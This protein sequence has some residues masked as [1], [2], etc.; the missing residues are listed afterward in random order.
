VAKAGS[1][2]KEVV[3][4]CDRRWITVY[5]NFRFS[6]GIDYFIHSFFAPPKKK[7]KKKESGNANFAPDGSGSQFAPFPCCLRTLLMS[8]L[9]LLKIPDSK[10]NYRIPDYRLLITRPKALLP[11]H[12]PYQDSY[13]IED[14]RTAG[15]QDRTTSILRPQ[16]QGRAFRNSPVG[17]FS[18]EPACR[19]G[20]PAFAKASA[21]E[22]RLHDQLQVAGKTARP[23]DRQPLLRLRLP[24][25]DIFY[26][27]CAFIYKAIIIN[28]KAVSGI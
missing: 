27:L 6:D 24:T 10:T 18:E 7:S 4:S 2:R 15:P 28:G 16:D 20:L 8:I 11:P 25:H 26:Y 3:Q 9:I 23:Q 1:R 17:C 13:L 12:L 5:F 21:D 22:A 19:A 14:C